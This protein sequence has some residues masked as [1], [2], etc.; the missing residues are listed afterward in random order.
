MNIK[1]AKKEC[2]II[3]FNEAIKKIKRK[4]EKEILERFYKLSD[5]LTGGYR[6]K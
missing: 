1:D 5:H 2:L 6:P 3:N 4:K